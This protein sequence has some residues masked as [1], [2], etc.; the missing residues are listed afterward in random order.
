[1]HI[2]PRRPTSRMAREKARSR[3]SHLQH[4]LSFGAAVSDSGTALLIEAHRA[5][6]VRILGSVP[7]RA[8]RVR[9]AFLDRQGEPL[10]ELAPAEL[11]PDAPLT[12]R[13]EAEY[14]RLDRRLSGQDRPLKADYD[15]FEALRLRSL[16]HAG[17]C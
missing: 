17:E 8:R 6:R 4:A 13:E 7:G 14:Q 2:L 1:M 11:V 12:D 15:R 16:L 10:R 9:I 3:G 5:H